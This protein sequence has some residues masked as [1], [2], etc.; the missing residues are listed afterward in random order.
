MNLADSSFQLKLSSV[1]IH[2]TLKIKGFTY[3][4]TSMAGLHEYKVILYG[5]KI[6]MLLSTKISRFDFLFTQ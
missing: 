1:G 5:D 2:S 4:G 6:A 3:H